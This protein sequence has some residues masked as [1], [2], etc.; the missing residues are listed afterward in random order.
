MFPRRI[1]EDL[2]LRL[3]SPNDAEMVFASIQQ[4]RVHLDNWLRWSAR[5]QTPDDMRTLI[6]RF[7]S[8]YE[9]HDGFRVGIWYH[10]SFVGEL[11]CHAINQES[12]KTEIGYWLVESAT[13]KGIVTRVCRDVIG[14]LFEQEK[15]HRIEIIAAADNVPSRA[16]AERLGFTFEGIKRESE[17]VTSRYMDHAAYSLLDR[18]W[19]TP[20]S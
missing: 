15:V 20:D 10:S 16:V 12:H 11:V 19:S 5:V 3:H 6:E 8:K 7:N 17:W 13:G 18:E 9:I 4:N 14:Y 1:G 2:E